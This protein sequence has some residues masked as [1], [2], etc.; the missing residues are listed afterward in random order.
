MLSGWLVAD[1]P[2]RE[3]TDVCPL[4]HGAICSSSRLIDNWPLHTTQPLNTLAVRLSVC[5]SIHLFI[6]VITLNNTRY[7]FRRLSLRSWL[8]LIHRQQ[9][10]MLSHVEGGLAWVDTCLLL[11]QKLGWIK[12]CKVYSY[13]NK[14]SSN[15]FCQNGSAYFKWSWFYLVWQAVRGTNFD[16]PPGSIFESCQ[17]Y[18][19]RATCQ[20]FYSMFN[21]RAKHISPFITRP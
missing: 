5:L 12:L 4:P 8:L 18:F 1:R 6:P 16:L 11:T 7:Y 2:R 13:S 17:L 21:P 20:N 15:N 19:F 3:C 10:P 14:I 9:Q